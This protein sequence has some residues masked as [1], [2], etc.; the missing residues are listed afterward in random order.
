MPDKVKIRSFIEIF[1]NT[2]GAVTPFQF[3]GD[4]LEPYSFEILNLGQVDILYKGLIFLRGA[5]PARKDCIIF[6]RVGT[7]KRSDILDLEF[8][9]SPLSGLC[10]IISNVEIESGSKD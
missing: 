2:P 7:F 3:Q 5:V 6:P 1:Q 4:K 10:Y 8:A 9:S